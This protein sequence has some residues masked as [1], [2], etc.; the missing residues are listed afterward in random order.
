MNGIGMVPFSVLAQVKEIK[1]GSEP[2]IKYMIY[3]RHLE[4]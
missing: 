1:N 4:R 3:V 2:V